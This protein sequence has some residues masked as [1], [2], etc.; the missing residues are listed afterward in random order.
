MSA[1]ATTVICG[2]SAVLALAIY[3]LLPL[4][5]KGSDTSLPLTPSRSSIPMRKDQRATVAHGE[6]QCECKSNSTDL[7]QGMTGALWS[8]LYRFVLNLSHVVGVR[9]V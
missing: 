9:G 2:A 5:R 1:R 3:R 6:E 7:D 8:P 4:Q